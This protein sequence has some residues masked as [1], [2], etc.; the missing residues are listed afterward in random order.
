MCYTRTGTI[1]RVEDRFAWV[2]YLGEEL[3]CRVGRRVGRLVPGDAVLL[4]RW[5]DGTYTV[6][7]RLGRRTTLVEPGIPSRLLAANLDQLVLVASGAPGTVSREELRF[8]RAS[9]ARSG[10]RTVLVLTRKGSAETAPARPPAASL[11]EEGVPVVEVDVE[12][13]QGLGELRM[14]LTG[15]ASALVG[16]EG[17]GRGRLAR[18]LCPDFPP[19]YTRSAVPRQGRGLPRGRQARGTGSLVLRHLPG[20]GYLAG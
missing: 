20:G 15:R 5:S 16:R 8:L 18:A 14:L 10:A 4:H 6:T 2:S 1:T 17:S 13:G 7:E 19:G 9:A 12:T 11:A 3:A